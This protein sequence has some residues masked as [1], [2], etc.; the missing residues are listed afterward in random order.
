MG[1]VFVDISTSLDGYVA[2]PEQTLQ[3]PLG[4]GGE[5]LHEWAFGAVS[6]REAHGLEGGEANVD[7]EVIEETL[8]RTGATIMGRR[9][10]SGGS[11]PWADDPNANGWWGEDPPFRAPVFFLTHHERETVDKGVTAYNFVTGGIEDA[12]ARARAV[13]GDR[14]VHIS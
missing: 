10:F 14:D 3:E 13:A 8:R 2:G 5:S 9:M 12:V 11:G 4:K 6:W 1:Q 7:S